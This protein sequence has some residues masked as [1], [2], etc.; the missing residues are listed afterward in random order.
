MICCW[1]RSTASIKAEMNPQKGIKKSIKSEISPLILFKILNLSNKRTI[2]SA[3]F[4]RVLQ[5]VSYGKHP[6]LH[7]E[8]E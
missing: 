2:C 8:Q 7:L 1:N 6:V 4:W 5:L 3:S